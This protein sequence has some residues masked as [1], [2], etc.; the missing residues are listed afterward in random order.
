MYRIT[1][2][3]FLAFLVTGCGS[4]TAN[5]A[6]S[7]PAISSIPQVPPISLEEATQKAL[8]KKLVAAGLAD[9][10]EQNSKNYDENLD[11]KKVLISPTPPPPTPKF[12]L[13]RNRLPEVCLPFLDY[14]NSVDYHAMTGCR[15][16]PS[17]TERVRFIDFT[18]IANED[19]QAT[20]K[21]WFLTSAS[22]HT[23]EKWQAV[24][25]ERKEDYAAGYHFL[26]EAYIDKAMLSSWLIEFQEEQCSYAITIASA[27]SALQTNEE[28]IKSLVYDGELRWGK[29]QR[30]GEFI[31]GDSFLSY[32]KRNNLDET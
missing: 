5:T 12:V 28:T 3:F 24:W 7:A 30:R 22:H 21:T 15:L 2:C 4:A 20:D 23:Q 27:A 6:S 13:T 14:L 10:A 9:S 18:P 32:F 25:P 17:Q 16:P 29:H 19:L 11:A 8:N 1:L 26:S 31:E